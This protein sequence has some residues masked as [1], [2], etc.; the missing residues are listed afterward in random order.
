MYLASLDGVALERVEE[1]GGR[2]GS[3]Q[4]EGLVVGREAV[5]AL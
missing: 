1:E 3:G 2:A 4:R 5:G